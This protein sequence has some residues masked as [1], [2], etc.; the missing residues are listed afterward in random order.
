MVTNERTNAEKKRKNIYKTSR[1]VAKQLVNERGG[2]A[3]QCI[4]CLVSSSFFHTNVVLD[5]LS[6]RDISL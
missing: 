2:C 6:L 5:A 3:V 1:I 4:I